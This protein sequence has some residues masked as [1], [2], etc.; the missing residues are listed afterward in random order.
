[1]VWDKMDLQRS[2]NT[3]SKFSLS[4]PTVLLAGKECVKMF[5]ADL[6]KIHTK[7]EKFQC[8]R[9]VAVFLHT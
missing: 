2:Y 1:M 4:G 9:G 8:Y 5:V 3:I 7:I 6:E